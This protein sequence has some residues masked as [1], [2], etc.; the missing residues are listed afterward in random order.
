MKILVIGG[1]GFLGTSLVSE[2]SKSKQ[3][4]IQVLDSFSQG[5]PE[6]PLKKKNI[7]PP[8]NGN[9]RNYYDVLRT[10]ERMCP[11]VVVHLAAYS[12]RPETFGDFRTC[13]EINY[14]GTANVAK[15][16]MTVNPRPSKL[17]FASSLAAAEPVNHYGIS[18]KAAEDL[19][20]SIFV[21]FPEMGVQLVTLR[22]SEIYGDGNPFTSTSLV[23]FLV[24]TML[25]DQNISLFS[26]QQKI[27]CLH[28]SDATA[29]FVKSVEF[30][31][32]YLKVDIGAGQGL[33]IKDIAH[34]LQELTK[35]KGQLRFL[36]DPHVV[37]QNL[38]ANTISARKVLG[39]EAV[40]DF[41]KELKSLVNK[42]KRKTK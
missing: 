20:E 28:I 35:H 24:D 14:Y 10:M 6:K 17:I 18:K 4:E 38:I 7:K 5:F 25:R 30:E 39:F 19:L 40:A 41:E 12:S 15:A 42:R 37:V 8:V 1:A 27:D 13:A 29:A 3:H 23:N 33:I 22:L 34:Q 36:E 2:L 32:K 11:D 21:R 16:C 9:I 26:V 31:G